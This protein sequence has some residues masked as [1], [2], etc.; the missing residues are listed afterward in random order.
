MGHGV[1]R[2]EHFITSGGSEAL[3]LA[4]LTL[5][6]P[7]DEILV[8]E[9]FYANYNSFAKIAGAHVRAV[10]TSAET[11]YRLPDQETVE[12]Y[13]TNKTRL[14]LLTN[15]GNPTG[16]VYNKKEMDMIAAVVKK[17]GLALIADEVYREFVYDGAYTS[18]GTYDDLADNLIIVDSVS[19][20]YSA[21]GARIGCLLCKMMTLPPRLINSARPASACL[22]WSRWEQPL[23]T[24]RRN[25]IWKR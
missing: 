17:H 19:K 22:Q 8:F 24:I 7:G 25:P 1:Q 5:C 21:C 12:K 2:K 4:A 23:S 11:G 14:I 9:P 10:P 6:D 13:I 16:V 15:P 18:F 3:E 20:R